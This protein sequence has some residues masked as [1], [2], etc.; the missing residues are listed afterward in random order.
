MEKIRDSLDGV[1]A[2]RAQRAMHS[3]NNEAHASRMKPCLFSPCPKTPLLGIKIIRMWSADWH[4]VLPPPGMPCCEDFDEAVLDKLIGYCRWYRMFGLNYPV[5]PGGWL[6][7]TYCPFC[8]RQLPESLF[9]KWREVFSSEFGSNWSEADITEEFL[10]D[11][12]WR[13][14]NL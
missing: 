4:G 11:E 8:G 6:P 13:T 14:R 7:I 9:E 3:L 1:R 2:S 10:T 12:W 5:P